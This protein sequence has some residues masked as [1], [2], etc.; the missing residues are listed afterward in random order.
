LKLR[1]VNGPNTDDRGTH[2]ITYT[3]VG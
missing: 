1:H 2:V 3:S